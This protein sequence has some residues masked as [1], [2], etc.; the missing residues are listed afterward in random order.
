VAGGAS[1]LRVWEADVGREIWKAEGTSLAFS[2]SPDGKFLAI[3][4]PFSLRLFGGPPELPRLQELRRRGLESNRTSW[5]EQEATASES[6][7]NWFAAEFHRR[8]L[9]RVQPASGPAHF[10][11]GLFLTR[12]GRHD[13]AKQEFITALGLKT[14]LSPLLAADCHAMLGQWNKAAEIYSAEATPRAT[15]SQTYVRFA[16]LILVSR[17]PAAYRAACEKMVKERAGRKDP[18]TASNQAWACA[19]GPDALQDM[20]PAVGLARLAV[21]AAP[22]DAN[23]RNT[24]GAVLYRAGKYDEAVK[25]L[26]AAIKMSGTGGTWTDHLFLAMAQHK[27][28]KTGEAKK[29]LAAAEKLLDGDPAWFWADK[30][31]RQLLREEATKLIRGK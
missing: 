3:C 5:H 22:A 30:L 24:L 15:D 29:S 16:Q 31:E 13:E 18:M 14:S 26:A 27:L 9:T 2:F 20:T 11:Y 19:V 8:W 1:G 10:K 23:A 17:G 21:K 25:E 28:G 7:R 4:S 12:R 6:A